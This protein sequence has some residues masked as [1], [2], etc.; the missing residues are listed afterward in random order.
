MILDTLSICV[1]VY[2][3]NVHFRS[4]STHIMTPWVRKVFIHILPKILLMKRPS[5]QDWH[6]ELEGQLLILIALE[7]YFID[8]YKLINLMSR[9]EMNLFQ[10]KL[11]SY[12]KEKQESIQKR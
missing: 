11:N 1:T 12:W 6:A 7:N 8:C 9:I 3:L 2:V 4:P 10:T 5:S